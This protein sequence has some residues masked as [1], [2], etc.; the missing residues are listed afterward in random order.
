MTILLVDSVPETNHFHTARSL[1]SGTPVYFLPSPRNGLLPGSDGPSGDGDDGK[2]RSNRNELETWLFEDDTFEETTVEPTTSDYTT[3]MDMTTD[4]IQF[5]RFLG[6]EII[7]EVNGTRTVQSGFPMPLDLTVDRALAE[8]ETVETPKQIMGNYSQFDSRFRK[9]ILNAPGIPTMNGSFL[10]VFAYTSEG[11]YTIGHLKLNLISRTNSAGPKMGHETFDGW[12][13]QIWQDHDYYFDIRQQSYPPRNLPRDINPFLD[14]GQIV[15]FHVLEQS[16][17]LYV[18]GQI[19][20]FFVIGQTLLF[21][22]FGP[23]VPFHVLGHIV[24]FFVIGQSVPYYVLGQS[25]QLVLY[26]VLVDR[27]I[28]LLNREK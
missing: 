26:S 19:V 12:G 27:W 15:P 6:A 24:P 2:D 1:M 11:T 13:N 9:K 10:V 4:G 7:S 18:L 5:D 23:I 22:V 16:V 21:Y 25:V 8:M 20:P 28:T 3:T 17:Q 14:L